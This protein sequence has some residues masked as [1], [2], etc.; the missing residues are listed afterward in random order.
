MNNDIIGH[1][2]SHDSKLLMDNGGSFKLT[3]AK[4][5]PPIATLECTGDLI[6]H[7]DKFPDDKT[8]I[9]QFM[10][11]ENEMINL[12]FN[13]KQFIDWMLFIAEWEDRESN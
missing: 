8:V 4:T 13:K 9:T 11:N 3:T 7:L 10:N 12:K 1:Y 6:L 5:T 2:A